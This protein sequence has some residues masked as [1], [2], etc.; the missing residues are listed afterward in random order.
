MSPF[1]I[2]GILKA[3]LTLA[4]SS[5]L[6]SPPYICTLVL[7][8]MQIAFAPPSSA[9]LAHSITLICSESTPSL[10]LT[11]TGSGVAS[12]TAFVMRKIRSG[13]RISALPSPLENILF[14][15]QPMFISNATGRATFAP[16]GWVK[17]SSIS[18]F[19]WRR[20]IPAA[21]AITSGSLPKICRATSP[22]SSKILPSLKVFLSPCVTA[23]ALTISVVVYSHPHSFATR[24]I[25]LSV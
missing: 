3:D 22:S 8:W 10:I 12:L 16:S 24:R 4:I 14:T 19:S 21:S 20:I 7:P 9:A 1:A 17:P 23:F 6:A 11:V 18:S 13:S 2:V 5:K 15:G 25:A